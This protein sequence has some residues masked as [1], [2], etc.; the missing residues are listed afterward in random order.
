MNCQPP[1]KINNIIS[2]DQT[3]HNKFRHSLRKYKIT[4]CVSDYLEFAR[5]QGFEPRSTG[6]KPAV[7]PLDDPRILYQNYKS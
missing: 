2:K 7:L 4:A 5:G 3:R 1:Y 6:S